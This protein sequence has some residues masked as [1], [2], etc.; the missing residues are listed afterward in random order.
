VD[1]FIYQAALLCVVCGTTVKQALIQRRKRLQVWKGELE[2]EGAF[3]PGSYPPRWA[4]RL[5]KGQSYS[6]VWPDGPFADG[7]GEADCPQHCDH[8]S[9]FLE[10]P[11]TQDGYD[12]VADAVIEAVVR[13]KM[14]DALRTWV[15]HYD[16][17]DLRSVLE[18]ATETRAK[19]ESQVA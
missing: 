8:C 10:N 2:M 9:V 1:C 15:D 18:R 13:G 5:R 12:Y 3:H 11:L 14:S 17:I 4:L 19:K 6:D 16:D 7:G